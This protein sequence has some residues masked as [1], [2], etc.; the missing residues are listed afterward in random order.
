[1]AQEYLVVPVAEYTPEDIS[2]QE[3]NVITYIGGYIVRKLRPKVCS[4]CQ[5]LLVVSDKDS[6]ST[7]PNTSFLMIKN[8]QDAKEGLLCPSVELTNCL[9]SCESHY[10]KVLDD[11]VYETG[12]KRKLVS[13]LMSEVD[14]S[15]LSC[16]S[17]RLPQLIVQLFINIRFHHTLREMNRNLQE[18][19]SRKNR[20]LLKFSH[21]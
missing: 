17:C 6:M 3:V 18:P 10:R 5:E 20:K 13:S 21:M 15:K 8:H 1:M 12:V 9:T 16:V 4:V 7:N 19:K 11:F 2:F 14:T